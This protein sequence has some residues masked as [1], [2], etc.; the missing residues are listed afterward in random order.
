MLLV[1]TVENISSLPMV[2]VEVLEIIQAV[3]GV[4]AVLELDGMVLRVLQLLVVLGA[5]LLF[6]VVLQGHLLQGVVAKVVTITKQG[7]L[8]NTV[9]VEVAV[10]Q[11]VVPQLDIV[12]AVPSMVQE[13]VEVGVQRIMVLVEQRVIGVPIL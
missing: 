9:G 13:V 7:I 5:I 6:R 2:P 1:L 4:V 3:M 11:L 8:V 12:V 10:G